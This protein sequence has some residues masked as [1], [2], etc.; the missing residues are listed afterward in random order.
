MLAVIV[1]LAIVFGPPHLGKPPDPSVIDADPRPD[2]YLL[3]YFAILALQPHGI[4]NYF[5][6]LGP[7][8]GG[9]VL[10]GLP[11]F[12]NSGERSPRKRPWAVA[13]MVMI[14]A[15]IGA[16]W[17]AGAKSDWSPNFKARPLDPKI[18]G[19]SSGPVFEGSK[20]FYSKACLNCHLIDQFGGRR[21]P[22]LTF[23]GDRLTRDDMVIRISNGGT[24]MP[25]YAHNM[26]SQ[27]MSEIIAFLQSR[28]IRNPSIP[29]TPHI[30][31]DYQVDVASGAQ[32]RD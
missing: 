5:M 18:V 26:T 27:E 31:S 15:S 3:W 12:S 22:D 21:G 32:K 14:V 8:V 4:E 23:V 28:S 10:L 29:R 30:G 2:W 13:I 7:M 20:L 16:L 24:N 9:L 11:F 1:T 25:S 6:V 17:W 19:A